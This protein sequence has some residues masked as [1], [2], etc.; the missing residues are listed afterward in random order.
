[1][2]TKWDSKVPDKEGW[3]WVKYVGK[4]GI[5]VCPAELFLFEDGDGV[6]CTG[7]ND[8]IRIDRLEGLKFGPAISF[9]S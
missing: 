1:M 4:R 7:R 6:V 9:P 8:H 2:K 5:V 3:Y